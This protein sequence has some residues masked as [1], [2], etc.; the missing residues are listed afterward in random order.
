MTKNTNIV[1]IA[2]GGTPMTKVKAYITDLQ[3]YG[4][5]PDQTSAVEDLL[6]EL[7]L[8]LDAPESKLNPALGAEAHAQLERMRHLTRDELR[9]SLTLVK[10]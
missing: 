8:H 2:V 1:H 3:L 10:E 6:D 5:G 4:L 7:E 9:R